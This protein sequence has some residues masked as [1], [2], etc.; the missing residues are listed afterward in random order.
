MRSLPSSFETTSDTVSMLSDI[1]IY[2]LGLGYYAEYSKRVEA[3]T[4]E[5]V[6]EV[7]KKYLLP[8]KMLVVAVGDRKVI[9]GGLKDLGL[10][11]VELR[12]SDGNVK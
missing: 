12:D 3:V 5:N 4:P 6:K 1:P 2:N 8:E 7:A 10:G 11:D 9:E